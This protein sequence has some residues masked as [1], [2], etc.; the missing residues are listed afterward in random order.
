MTDQLPQGWTTAQIS[1]ICD[2]PKEKGIDS[3]TPYLEI[4]NVSIVSKDYT[5]T[6]KLS[7]KG[8]RIAKRHDVLVSKVRP[9]RGAITYIREEELHISSAFT[10]LRNKGT[11]AEKYLWMFLA[12]NHDYLNHLGENCTGTMYPTISDEVVIE[13]EVPLAP[14]NEQRRIVAKLEKL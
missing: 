10:V 3:V 4:G 8:C 11:M 5:L 12:W 6:E 9:T 14:L 13:F 7:V 2:V 1:E